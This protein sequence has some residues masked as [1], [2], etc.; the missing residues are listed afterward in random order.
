MTK[1]WGPLAM[2]FLAVML[3]ACSDSDSTPPAANN[4]PPIVNAGTSS[5]INS[6]QRVQLVGS[7]TD[8]DGTIVSVQWQQVGGQVVALQNANTLT[9]FFDAPVLNEG[10]RALTFELTAVDNL[11]ASSSARV[12]I[13]LVQ[14]ISGSAPVI[15]LP[16]PEVRANEGEEVILTASANDSDGTVIRYRWTLE[17]A[18]PPLPGSPFVVIGSNNNATPEAEFVAPAVQEV[19]ELQFRLTVDDNASPPNTDTATTTVTVYPLPKP[20]EQ[21]HLYVVDEAAQILRFVADDPDAARVFSA[22]TDFGRFD[23]GAAERMIDG[24]LALTADGRLLQ[25]DDADA[26][27]VQEVCAFGQRIQNDTAAIDTA[28]DADRDRRYTLA[29][30]GAVESYSGVAVDH[31]RGY[32]IVADTFSGGGTQDAR[33][34]HVYGSAVGGAVGLVAD[35]PLGAL[36][37]DLFYVADEGRGD[38]RDDTLFVTLDSGRIAVFENFIDEVELARAQADDDAT[39]VGQQIEIDGLIRVGEPGDPSVEI[40]T[41]LRGIAYHRESDRLIVSDVGDLLAAAPASGGNDGAIF[42]LSDVTAASVTG[43]DRTIAADAVVRGQDGANPLGDPVDLAL[44]GRDLV[45]ADAA[46][47]RVYVYAD[48]FRG[49]DETRRPAPADTPLQVAGAGSLVVQPLDTEYLQN[50][51]VPRDQRTGISPGVDDLRPPLQHVNDVRGGLDQAVETVLVLRQTDS[52]GAPVGEL[53][54]VDAGLVA[55]PSG[56]A[57]RLQFALADDEQVR[58]LGLAINGDVFATGVVPFEPAILPPLIPGEEGLSTTRVLNSVAKNRLAMPAISPSALRDRSIALNGAENVRASLVIDEFGLLIAADGG[59]LTEDVPGL[60]I[61]TVCGNG[62][63]LGARIKTVRTVGNE[64]INLVPTD[65]DYDGV[66]GDLYISFVPEEGGVGSF[67]IIRNFDRYLESLIAD[68]SSP[69]PLGTLLVVQPQ[70]D[71]G[72]GVPAPAASGYDAIEY[73]PQLDRVLLAAAGDPSD[74]TDGSL[75]IIGRAGTPASQ[76]LVDTILVTK[77]IMGPDTRL[78]NPRDLAWDG[79]NLF[80]AE[81]GNGELLRFDN[82]AALVDAAQVGANRLPDAR[83]TLPGIR[84]I[85][86]VPAYVGGDPTQRLA[87]AD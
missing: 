58:G 56:G 80:V 26:S 49:F 86:P 30:E 38:G 70:V 37:R 32:V 17:T 76:I 61:H 27:G 53:L 11:G 44:H 39:A 67:G 73:I 64:D 45:V 16:V 13:T 84:A 2:A 1:I 20:A 83:L 75:L 62:D 81:Q 55:L 63:R 8:P 12:V 40:G 22:D 74:N 34:I 23:P 3:P 36:P 57:P 21:A 65:L 14:P 87:A 29:R 71:D 28:D 46:N 54:R 9:P 18:E 77:R 85:V 59:G 35:I 48:I 60:S 68:P 33:G 10:R 42:I 5:D 15:E 6:G 31:A 66:R 78:G 50:I 79:L 24:A 41:S 19:T 7:A 82:L 4:L 51:L 52:G 69:V 43:F 72:T 47:N 25:T